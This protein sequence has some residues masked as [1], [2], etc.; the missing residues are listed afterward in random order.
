MDTIKFKFSII[1]LTW[2][3]E[4]KHVLY[5]LDNYISVNK[6]RKGKRGGG[7]SLYLDENITYRI[8]DDLDYFDSELEMVVVEICKDVFKTNSNVIVG[9]IYRIPNTPIEVL[10]DRIPDILNT[11]EKEQ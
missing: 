6:F 10:N 5:E 4:N 8:R 2:L 7:V 11:A 9:L 1:G 3:D